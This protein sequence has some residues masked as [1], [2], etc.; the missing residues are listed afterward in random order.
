[1]SHISLKED[2]RIVLD[3]RSSVLPYLF[4]LLVGAMFIFVPCFFVLWLFPK[5][6]IYQ[7]LFFVTIGVGSLL[8]FRALF[9]W[10]ANVFFITTRRLVDVYHAGIFHTEV[11]EIPYDQLEEVHGKIVGFWGTCFQYGML[12]IHTPNEKEQITV[13]N[14]R[15]PVSRQQEIN[16]LRERFL[17]TKGNTFRGSIKAAVVDRLYEAEL[18]DLLE[19]Q[20]ILESRIRRLQKEEPS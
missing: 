13:Q 2:E 10:R 16:E 12:T 11:S 8:F 5:G 17:T 20:R 4:R 14:I 9:F 1:M 15:H 19:I 6:W 3:V 18:S 7:A